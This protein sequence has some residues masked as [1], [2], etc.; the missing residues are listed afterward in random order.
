MTE[1][2]QA[3][4]DVDSA[5]TFSGFDSEAVKT[6]RR[7]HQLCTA[8][9]E[10]KF[11]TH[12]V[13]FSFS[14]GAGRQPCDELDYAGHEALRSLMM[15]LCQLWMQNERTRF[16]TVLGILRR[17]AEAVGS[18]SCVEAIAQL[19]GIGKRYRE[20]MRKTMMSFVERERPLVP[21]KEFSAEDV[22]HNWLYG[23]HFH[24]D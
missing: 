10:T 4:A 12:G 22:I 8:V 13:R 15:D 23:G 21:V 24:W 14:V 19:D 9:G 18:P 17:N 7:Y 5:T 11:F 20:S 1:L 6:L 2:L 3:I 16:Q